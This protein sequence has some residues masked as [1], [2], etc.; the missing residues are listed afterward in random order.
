M[1]MSDRL[2]ASGEAKSS[3]RAEI[4]SEVDSVAAENFI[5]VALLSSTLSSELFTKPVLGMTA[6][7]TKNDSAATSSS[8]K[9]LIASVAFFVE[10]MASSLP[11]GSD[12]RFF[13]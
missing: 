4:A 1:F 5:T 7:A 12:K 9:T 6:V 13:L 8:D 3:G 2:S 10:S 11:N